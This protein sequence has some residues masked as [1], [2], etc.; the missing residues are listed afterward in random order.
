[1]KRNRRCQQFSF[2]YSLFRYFASCSYN[3]DHRLVQD[4][5][6][7]LQKSEVVTYCDVIL[8]H[9]S[10]GAVRN[11]ELLPQNSGLRFELRT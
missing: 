11:T 9:L 6:G 4:E 1:M 5:M 7:S 3:I 10:D 2:T 8:R